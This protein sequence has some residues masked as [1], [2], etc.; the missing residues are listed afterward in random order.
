MHDHATEPTAGPTER[1]IRPPQGWNR[2]LEDHSW[3][4]WVL[5]V[6]VTLGST[7]VLGG[8]MLLLE[9]GT[10]ESP[11][12]WADTNL[13]LLTGLALVVLSLA[14]YLTRQQRRLSLLRNQLWESEQAYTERLNRNFNRL[15]AIL[16]VS[17]TMGSETDPQAVLDAITESCLE[18][19]PSDR[20]SLML[21]VRESGE[22][23][24]RSAAG[25]GDLERLTGVRLKVGQGVAGWVAKHQK[26]VRLGRHVDADRYEGFEPRAGAPCAAMVVPIVLRG[27]L[28]GV[29]NV[30]SHDG[31]TVYTDE[32]IQALLVF[33]ENAGLCCR[34][35][36]Q[37]EWMRE[38]ISRLD[39]AL[40]AK[41]TGH[42]K[43]A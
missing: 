38:T 10:L 36:E 37:S 19:F 29:L 9:Q 14:F 42:R 4:N 23:E 25:T 26:P 27:E 39:T 8:V 30:S 35:A 32:D 18:T 41:E 3:R 31:E 21:L 34:H 22:L 7:L 24:V 40:R 16:N 28:I 43:A 6:S 11:W 15:V 33:A 20:V 5:I 13:V 2:Q 12:P 17:R 1:P